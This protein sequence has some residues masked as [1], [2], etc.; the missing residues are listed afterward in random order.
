MNMFDRAR[1]EFQADFDDVRAAQNYI[2]MANRI[3]GYDELTSLDKAY[4]IGANITLG[5]ISQQNV[6]YCASL[7]DEVCGILFPSREEMSVE[8]VLEDIDDKESLA[9][10]NLSAHCNYL[11]NNCGINDCYAYCFTFDSLASH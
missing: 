10:Q 6:Q 11:S 1:R 9:K 2:N 4:Y 8:E 5:N 7:G 3:Y